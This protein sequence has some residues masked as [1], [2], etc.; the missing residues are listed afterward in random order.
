M[1]LMQ[2]ANRLKFGAGLL[3]LGSLAAMA[4]PVGWHLRG[5]FAGQTSAA[6]VIA[7]APATT[8]RKSTRLNS[9]HRNTSR[10]PSSA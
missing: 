4:A 6:P 2:W 3:M 9:S 5:E 8:D 10:M 1:T 7:A